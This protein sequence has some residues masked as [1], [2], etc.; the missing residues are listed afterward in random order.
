MCFYRNMLT[1]KHLLL[2]PPDY[3][4]ITNLQDL[5]MLSFSQRGELIA[6]RHFTCVLVKGLLANLSDLFKT[7]PAHKKG[8]YK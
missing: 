1:L 2:N 8:L 6:Y 4:V 5:E 3:F 7:L